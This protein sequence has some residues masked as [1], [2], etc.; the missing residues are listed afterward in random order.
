MIFVKEKG[1][2]KKGMRHEK[3]FARILRFLFRLTGNVIIKNSRL[4]SKKQLITI[5]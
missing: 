3:V 4:F 1:I 2:G 5:L